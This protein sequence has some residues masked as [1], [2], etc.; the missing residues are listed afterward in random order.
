M[1]TARAFDHHD[2]ELEVQKRIYLV[3]NDGN[4]GNLQN[5]HASVNYNL[6]SEWLIKFDAEDAS[7]NKAEQVP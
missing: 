7:G 3:N 6:R 2:G 5:S 4:V 1:P